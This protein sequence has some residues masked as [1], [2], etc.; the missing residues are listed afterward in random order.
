MKYQLKGLRDMN[1]KTGVEDWFHQHPNLVRIYRTYL[2]I[3]VASTLIW[4]LYATT[5]FH[6]REGLTQTWITLQAFFYLPLLFSGIFTLHWMN[7]Y[8]DTKDNIHS[9]KYETVVGPQWK[10]TIVPSNSVMTYKS[11]MGIYPGNYGWDRY[12]QQKARNGT[13]RRTVILEQIEELIER[14]KVRMRTY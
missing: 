14:Q 3:A 4:V 13:G 5:T 1:F 6:R 7:K 2:I 8:T 12:T 9:D 11:L 10:Q